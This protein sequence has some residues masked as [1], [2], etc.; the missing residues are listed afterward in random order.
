[1]FTGSPFGVISGLSFLALLLAVCVSDVRTRRIPNRL[2]ATLA[3][4]GV[5]FSVATFGAGAGMVHAF[6]GLGLG[7]VI[8]LPFHVVRLIGAGDVK[9]FS[10]ASAWL[11]MRG[12]L[13]AA[14]VAALVGGVLAFFWMLRARGAAGS[15]RALGLAVVAPSTLMREES[16]RAA[17]SARLPYGVALAAGAAVAALWPGLVFGS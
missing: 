8:W 11:G 16:E 7:L 15:A 6:A 1:M 4:A 3:I 9:L 2:V 5:A 10:A 14:L 12:A 13:E 17:G